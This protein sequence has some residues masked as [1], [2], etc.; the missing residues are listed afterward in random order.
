MAGSLIVFVGAGIGGMLRF[1][2]DL[3]VPA[4]CRM[5][6][7]GCALDLVPAATIL[8]NITGSML[9]GY[10]VG[11]PDGALGAN[12]RL[13]LVVGFAG[14]FTTL[15]AFNVQTLLL[16]QQGET[17]AAFSNVAVTLAL[18]FVATLVGYELAGLAH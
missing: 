6:P 2:L 11:L 10:V 12:A 4:A 1:W 3:L 17:W 5:V 15:S 9:A 16:L 7:A 14:G 13:L 8:A 18:A